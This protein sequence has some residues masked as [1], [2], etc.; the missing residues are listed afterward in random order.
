MDMNR[1]VPLTLAAAGGLLEYLEQAIAEGNY[2]ADDIAEARDNAVAF[3]TGEAIKMMLDVE[4]TTEKQNTQIIVDLLS[5]DRVDALKEAW[6]ALGGDLLCEDI[7][8]I[9]KFIYAAARGGVT[10]Y[11]TEFIARAKKIKP[12]YKLSVEMCMSVCASDPDIAE[13]LLAETANI[14][15]G[16]IFAGKTTCD[17]VN[18]AVVKVLLDAGARSTE[19]SLCAVLQSVLPISGVTG[20][21]ESLN[22]LVEAGA[23]PERAVAVLPWKG[24]TR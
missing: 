2:D 7:H 23:S 11:L 20:A 6:D 19:V 1:G 21:I 10:E 16:V 12:G 3:G 8:H 22:M 5:L 24:T 14:S 18:P 17:Y 4:K 13:I 9:E 15:S